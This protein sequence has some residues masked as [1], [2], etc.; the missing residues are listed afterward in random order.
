MGVK[1]QDLTLPFKIEAK[2]HVENLLK[3]LPPGLYYHG[4]SHT[5][6]YVYPEAVRIGKSRRIK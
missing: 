4:P 2:I 1:E 6:N 5:F 3:G